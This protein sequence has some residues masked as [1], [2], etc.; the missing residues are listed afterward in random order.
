MYAVL[1]VDQP[2][3]DHP[4]PLHM[5]GMGIQRQGIPFR[6]H[7]SSLSSTPRLYQPKLS[8]ADHAERDD[9]GSFT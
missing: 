4:W 2:L 8:V 3:H 6:A 5:K 9:R 1:G 7:V